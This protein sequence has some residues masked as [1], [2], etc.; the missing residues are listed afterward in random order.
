MTAG[1][2]VLKVDH[3]IVQRQM[4]LTFGDK[5]RGSYD[6]SQMV[7]VRPALRVDWSDALLV[8]GLVTEKLSLFT[9]LI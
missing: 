1:Q 2:E 7:G 3:E 9:S 8:K 5:I 4:S 6:K